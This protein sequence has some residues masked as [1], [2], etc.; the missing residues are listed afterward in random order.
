MISAISWVPRGAAKLVPVEAEPPTQEEIDEA[1]K[2]IAQHTEYA[3]PPLPSSSAAAALAHGHDL[4]RAEV[5]ATPTRTPT[6]ARRMATWRS[7][8]PPMRRRR[9]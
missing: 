7:M 4:Q 1:I 8:P 6:T 5:G 9:R 3:S 2:A